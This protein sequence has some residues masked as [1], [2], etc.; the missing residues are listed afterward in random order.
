MTAE[1]LIMTSAALATACLPA[2]DKHTP[3]RDLTHA[4]TNAR[5][6]THDAAEV[7]RE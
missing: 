4:M 6:L 1:F 5:L 7:A 2:E 3:A